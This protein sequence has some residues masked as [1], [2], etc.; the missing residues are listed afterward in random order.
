MKMYKRNEL[1]V[2]NY[3]DDYENINYLYNLDLDE[4]LFKIKQDLEIYGRAVI[5][6]SNTNIIEYINQLYIR[7]SEDGNMFYKTDW[8]K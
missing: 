5:K 3:N 2:L 1:V 7:V 4:V 8:T 6:K